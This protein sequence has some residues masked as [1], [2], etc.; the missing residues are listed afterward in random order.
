MKALI[1]WRVIMLGLLVMG[2]AGCIY[3]PS[4]IGIDV[5]NPLERAIECYTAAETVC[6]LEKSLYQL[7]IRG[8]NEEILITEEFINRLQNGADLEGVQEEVSS[9]VYKMKREDTPPQLSGIGLWEKYN[10]GDWVRFIWVAFLAV[11]IFSH[12]TNLKERG[13]RIRIRRGS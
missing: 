4:R 6:Y 8:W 3:V 12:P 13:K 2:F 7:R 5:V 9:L 10:H 1:P 11:F